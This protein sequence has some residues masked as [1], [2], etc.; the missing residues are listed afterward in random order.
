MLASAWTNYEVK[1]FSI[2]Q[3]NSW[4][5][6]E[7]ALVYA[8]PERVNKWPNFVIIMMMMIIMIISK[9]VPHEIRNINLRNAV[10]FRSFTV[11]GTLRGQNS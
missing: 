2:L 5:H 8:R 9:N 11:E 6:F 4:Q 3:N 10:I 7:R 1:Q